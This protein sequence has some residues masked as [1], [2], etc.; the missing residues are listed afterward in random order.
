MM[1]PEAQVLLL[2]ADEF[3]RRFVKQRVELWSGRVVP[4]T[5][6]SSLHA[7]TAVEVAFCLRQF[8]GSDGERGRVL[9]EAGF[10]VA[11]NPDLVLAPDVAVVRPGRDL[12]ARGWVPGAPDLAVEVISPDDQWRDVQRKVARYLEG[13][14]DLVWVADPEQRLLHVFRP[15]QPPLTLTAAESVTGDPVLAGL[16]L[17]VAALFPAP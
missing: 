5:P 7:R 1:R 14:T 10:L 6:V 2:S 11:S 13:G 3:Y 8:V 9:V 4:M 17:P 15:D 16:S 12:P